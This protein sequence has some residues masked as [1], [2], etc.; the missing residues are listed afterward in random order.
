M[1]LLRS[2][3]ELLPPIGAMAVAD[4]PDLLEDVEG[5]VHRGWDGGGVDGATALDQLDPRDVPSRSSKDG[6]YRSA[7]RRPAH[8]P[9]V[10]PLTH[11]R[12]GFDE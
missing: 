10:Q 4:E 5:A 7:L 9:I 2:H 8:A 3:V 11:A 6:N 12:P 1:L